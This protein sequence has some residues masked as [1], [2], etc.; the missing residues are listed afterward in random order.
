L[1]KHTKLKELN[2]ADFEKN[3]T[4]SIVD[5]AWRNTCAK[6]MSW[7]N[8]FNLRFTEQKIHYLFTNSRRSICL[9]PWLTTNKEV[10][11]F[12][13]KGFAQ[14]NQQIQEEKKLST[15]RLS[16]EQRRDWGAPRVWLD[17]HNKKQV[18]ETIARHAKN[19]SQR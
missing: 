13:F 15:R 9:E 16:I 1:K 3:I 18:T 10:I 4:L 17:K 14:E 12:L 11:S 5:E 6:W 2:V 7:N 19:Q 8:P